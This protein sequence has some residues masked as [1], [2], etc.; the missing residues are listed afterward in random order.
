MINRR[1]Y[2]NMSRYFRLALLLYG[3]WTNHASLA[4]RKT[5]AHDYVKALMHVSDVM[6]V[7][8]TP[9]V[10]AARYYSYITLAANEALQVNEK[11]S[12]HS[13]IAMPRIARESALKA[14][15]GFS[16]LYALLFASK[17]LLPSGYRLDVEIQKTRAAY[18]SSLPAAVFDNSL[19]WAEAVTEKVISYSA[20]DG[21]STFSGL[22]KYRL[23]KGDAFWKPTPPAFMQAIEPNWYRL[24]PFFVDSLPSF[25][26][27]PCA[28][29]DTSRGSAFFKLLDEIYTTSKKL[30]TYQAGIASFWD[31]NPFALQQMG[32]VEFALKKM[33]PGAH[34]IGITGL[35]CLKKDLSLEKTAY[36]HTL[37]S[38]A[39]NDAFIACWD[40]KY[41]SNRVRP[42]T[43]INKLIDPAWHPLLQ[44]PPFP[45]YPSGHSVISAAAAVVLTDFFGDNFSF[46]DNTEIPFGLPVR[47]FTSFTQAADEA[48]ISRLYGGIHFRDAVENGKETGKRVGGIVLKKISKE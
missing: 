37:V 48:A 18:R 33:S 40:E 19:K 36:I 1:F 15:P 3:I 43:A 25:H 24:R 30:T 38:M 7:D 11:Y 44:T 23:K 20:A 29:Y 12:F 5:T 13:K 6:I 21:F 28:P 35:C 46:D 16:C 31:C 41:K 2:I 14:D 39:I 32:H 9:P 4:Q 42:E 17:K 22:P 47:H 10:N 27:A 34:W 45:E 8:A 26:T